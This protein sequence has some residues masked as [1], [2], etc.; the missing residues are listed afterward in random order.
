M[1][2][3][4]R[5][6][7]DKRTYLASAAER[8][9]FL[10]PFFA[11][12]ALVFAFS[13]AV[14]G[15]ASAASTTH[16]GL[17]FPGRIESRG[18]ERVLSDR[19]SGVPFER[20]GEFELSDAGGSTTSVRWNANDRGIRFDYAFD[21]VLR[22]DPGLTG[23]HGPLS[24]S[25]FDLSLSSPGFRILDRGPFGLF[26][27]DYRY[28]VGGAFELESDEPIQLEV[29]AALGWYGFIDPFRSGVFRP[30]GDHW[31]G[32]RILLRLD[33]D[34]ESRVRGAGFLE[35]S[36]AAVPEPSSALL[37]GLALAGLSRLRPGLDAERAK[38]GH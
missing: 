7:P 15:V 37:L 20:S 13:F 17:F 2:T 1:T 18:D 5:K 27:R 31:L 30:A 9:A 10:S 11:S 22:P 35:V 6:R 23:V 32:T 8:P 28:A 16:W 24:P 33:G 36:V 4:P 26:E 34:R 12:F 19:R 14:P 25:R 29:D 21:L 38:R 3:P